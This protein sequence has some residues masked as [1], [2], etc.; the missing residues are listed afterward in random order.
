MT[1]ELK[2]AQAPEQ[3]SQSALPDGEQSNEG[4]ASPS[5][6]YERRY[7]DTQA[8][9][10]KSQQAL[11]ERERE[12]EAKSR[13]EADYRDK[14]TAYERQLAEVKEFQERI[15][16]TFGPTPVVAEPALTPEQQAEL[17]RLFQQTPSYKKFQELEKSY[18]ERQQQ[19]V[20]AREY[21]RRQAID[22]A[23][24]EIEREYGLVKTDN[25][26]VDD[27]GKKAFFDFLAVNPHFV[28]GLNNAQSKEAA[29]AVLKQALY[30]QKYPELEKNATAEGAKIVERKLNDMEAATTVEKP[31][32]SASTTAKDIQI[33]PNTRFG[34]IWSQAAAIAEQDV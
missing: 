3:D 23:G 10:T 12:L 22:E 6:D 31:G 18:T 24:A 33:G 15:K 30:A 8:A 32:R 13:A 19:E 11:K 26:T 16:Q 27:S 2:D 34:D 5:G 4:G 9:Y 17:D 29:K 25:G 20:Q 1:D 21:A 14:L 7:K 28:T